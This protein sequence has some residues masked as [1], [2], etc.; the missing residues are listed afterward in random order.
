MQA[1]I[2]FTT[3]C[4]LD[5]IHC[6]AAEFRPAPD[7]E[8]DHLMNVLTQ[9]LAEGYDE[10]HL[11]G[12]EP[13]IRSDVFDVLDLFEQHGV[14][15]A[16]STNSLLLNEEKIRKLLGYKGLVTF[17][18]SLDGATQETHDTMRGQE[19]FEYALQMIRHAVT[20]RPDLNS[21]TSIGLNYTLTK[22]NRHEITDVFNLA[23]TLGVDYV[24]V[25]SLSLLGNAA[26]HKDELYLPEREELT[27]LQE[28]ATALRKINIGR[29]INRMNPMTFNLELFTYEWKCRLMKLSKYVA[30]HEGGSMCNSGTGTIYVG[31]DGTIYPCEG[32]RVFIDMLEEILG[33]YERPNISEYTIAEAK[34]TESFKKMVTFLHDYERVFSSIT[35][36]NTCGHLGKCTI[37]PLFALA[38]GNVKKC[39]EEVLSDV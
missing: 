33:P 16:I 27:A 6:C 3:R 22:I 12:G 29:K 38:D 8:T 35:P 20:Q 19:S 11:Q 31:V 18:F 24:T 28:G 9:L 39:A 23:D 7:W 25:L 17:T 32:T 10:F 15:F 5:C 37:C 2:E 26:L 34:Q 36:C 1:K 14:V 30:T 4:N 21:K 13:F